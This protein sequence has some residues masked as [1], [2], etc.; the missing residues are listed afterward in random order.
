MIYYFRKNGHYEAP[1]QGQDGPAVEVSTAG[2]F[3]GRQASSASRVGIATRKEESIATDRL[4][5]G[6]GGGEEDQVPFCEG[7]YNGAWCKVQHDAFKD[8]E[9]MMPMMVTQE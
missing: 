4:H 5:G 2:G 9:R 6:R 3:R 1:A 8:S 7:M